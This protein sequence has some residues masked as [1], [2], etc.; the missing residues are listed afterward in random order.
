V[1]INVPNPEV[2]KA[3]IAHAEKHLRFWNQ[4]YFIHFGGESWTTPLSEV[5]A[6]A[7]VEAPD[8]K[9]DCGTSACLAGHILLAQGHSWADLAS[10][11][12]PTAALQ[13][14]GYEATSLECSPDAI[15]FDDQIFGLIGEEVFDDDG[16]DPQ[17]FRVYALT[18][19]N[20]EIFKAEVSRLTGIEL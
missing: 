10:T 16:D 13:A 19:E 7:P 1:T 4:N 20:F 6:A 3:G 15:E 18:Q 11:D 17:Y 5:I 14:L 8:G 12:I 9:P 2:L